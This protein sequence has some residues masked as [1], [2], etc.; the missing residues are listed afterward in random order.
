MLIKYKYND[1]TLLS[2]G[3]GTNAEPTVRKGNEL[4][5][6]ARYSEKL[7]QQGKKNAECGWAGE[8]VWRVERNVTGGLDV[9]SSQYPG[10]IA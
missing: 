5:R 10:V 3:M 6:E 2:V 9:D 7:D 1:T 4:V 8:S